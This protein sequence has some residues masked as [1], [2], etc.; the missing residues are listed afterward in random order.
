FAIAIGGFDLSVG[1]VQGL[2]ACVTASLLGVASMPAAVVGGIVV[3]LVVGLV[4]GLLIAKLRVPAFVATL[5]TLGVARGAAL[6]YT[7]GQSVLIVGHDDFAAL[8]SAKPL[9][10]PLPL[11]I[12]LATLALLAVVL[13]RTPFGRHV[14]AIGGNRAAAVAAGIQVDRVTVAV[15][16][17][18]GVTAALSGVMLASQLMVVDG[19]LGTGF[20]LRVI[21][22]SVLGGT[23]LAGGS[24]NLV[25]AFLAA[26]LLATI[27]AS[28]NLLN[29]PG[30]YQ[31]LA[32][33]LLLIVALSLD[34]A[35]N[36][37]AA[38]AA[39]GWSR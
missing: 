28:L 22:I 11:L 5:G 31:Y 34:T 33:G 37:L 35:R 8:N 39:R 25:G 23:S 17:L 29:V 20:E 26:L 32:V 14:C 15:F 19:T 12:A 1:S 9:G 16:A 27:N 21:A 13:Y 36:R 10:L 3:G 7:N 38:A 30:A 6:L 2:A 4:N 24:G 18:V